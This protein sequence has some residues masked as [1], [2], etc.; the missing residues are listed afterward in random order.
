M[1]NKESGSRRSAAAVW[2]MRR[3]RD[4]A[5]QPLPC[6]LCFFFSPITTHPQMTQRSLSVS[7]AATAL[8]PKTGGSISVSPSNTTATFTK[9]SLPHRRSTLNLP[10][11]MVFELDLAK[12][13]DCRTHPNTE[14]GALEAAKP[15]E[16]TKITIDLQYGFQ[17]CV[18]GLSREA[19][20]CCWKDLDETRRDRDRI[21]D[22][23]T[24]P[25]FLCFVPLFSFFFVDCRLR[26]TLGDSDLRR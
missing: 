19:G 10:L 4:K 13:D 3:T 16:D 2:A 5:H 11:T 18:R 7:T 8:S 12:T 25:F 21:T 17:V 23:I 6:Y 24:L 26:L 22:R 9:G 20:T 15:N 1:E 14:K